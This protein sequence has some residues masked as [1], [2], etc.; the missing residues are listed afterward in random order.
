MSD[1]SAVVDLCAW[2]TIRVAGRDAL[3]WLDDLVS[4]GLSGLRPPKSRRSLLLTPT[5]RIRADFHVAALEDGY[6]V[7]QD[8]IQSKPIDD[9]LGPYVLSSQVDIHA[10]D[11]DFQPATWDEDALTPMGRTV[12]PPAMSLERFDEWRIRRGLPRFGIDLDEE[13]LPQEAGWE[14]FV[15]FT[16]GCFMGQEAMAK[17]RNMGGHPTRV[18]RALRADGPI[19]SGQAVTANGIEVGV[20]TSAAGT[21][22]IARI[23]WSARDESLTTESGVSLLDRA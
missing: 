12:E 21:D 1:Q 13:S 20:V 10:L 14:R 19:S 7:I 4:A 2:R 5:G 9:L 11:D 6:L 23:S 22:A 3:E 16:K 18:V 17:I 15:D 8:P